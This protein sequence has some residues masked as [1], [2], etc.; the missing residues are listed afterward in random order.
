MK[1]WMIG[2]G[3]ALAVLALLAVGLLIGGGLLGRVGAW[4]LAGGMMGGYPTMHNWDGGYLTMHRLG[5][6]IAMV[7][8][9]AAVIG[10]IVLLVA[11]LAR[12][13]AQDRPAESS[14][15]EILKRRYASGEIDQEEYE[16]IRNSL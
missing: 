6:G 10:G 13:P 7:L 4:P 15:L 1:R 11:T 14:A 5:G 2:I 8:F 9:W 12:R 3:I 16:R